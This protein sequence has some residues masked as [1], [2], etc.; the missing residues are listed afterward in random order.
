MVFG[1]VLLQVYLSHVQAGHFMEGDLEAKS[2]GCAVIDKKAEVKS[3]LET[4]YPDSWALV[5]KPHLV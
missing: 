2:V 1:T 3:T 5:L 4:R